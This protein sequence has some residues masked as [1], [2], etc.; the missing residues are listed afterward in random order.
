MLR[1]ASHPSY[2]KKLK[3]KH[4]F[5][6]FTKSKAHW[7]WTLD[8][9][10]HWSSIYRGSIKTWAPRYFTLPMTMNCFLRKDIYIILRHILGREICLYC[11]WSFVNVFTFVSKYIEIFHDQIQMWCL[12]HMLLWKHHM[13]SCLFGALHLHICITSCSHL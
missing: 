7:L 5:K 1:D 12:F 13:M 10:G 8:E 3:K 9:D 11:L 6:H 2:I 4:C